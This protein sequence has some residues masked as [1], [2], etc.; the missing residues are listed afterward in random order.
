MRFLRFRRVAIGEHLSSYYKIYDKLTPHANDIHSKLVKRS[1]ISR[2]TLFISPSFRL[3]QYFKQNVDDSLRS[4]GGRKINWIWMIGVL[5]LAYRTLTVCI[6]LLQKSEAK[7]LC[8]DCW[9]N[10]I[11]SGNIKYNFNQ[12][13]YPKALSHLTHLL[14]QS[15]YFPCKTVSYFVILNFS[16]WSL[17]TFIGFPISFYKAF[18]LKH[19]LCFE[20]HDRAFQHFKIFSFTF[21]YW[22]LRLFPFSI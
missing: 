4:L 6:C 18:Y 2:N 13:I 10:F 11:S 12:Q 7:E 3:I 22:F 21:Y 17:V 9:T 8:N 20:G 1:K 15:I 5:W 16:H 19:F 14:Q